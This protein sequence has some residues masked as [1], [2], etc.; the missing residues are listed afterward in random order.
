MILSFE[1]SDCGLCEV[2]TQSQGSFKDTVPR[3]ASLNMLTIVDSLKSTSII[4]IKCY[5]G[6]LKIIPASGSDAKQLNVSTIR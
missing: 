2:K 5:D 1:F 3:S 6:I 4:A